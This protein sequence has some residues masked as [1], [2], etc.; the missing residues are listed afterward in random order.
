MGGYSNGKLGPN[1]PITREQLA[2]I[3]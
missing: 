3:L 1:D 2:A